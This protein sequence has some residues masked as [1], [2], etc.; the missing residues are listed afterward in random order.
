MSNGESF[1]GALVVRWRNVVTRP[2]R[3]GVIVVSAAIVVGIGRDKW[4]D[5]VKAQLND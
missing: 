3:R 1:V 5:C 4:T 2:V